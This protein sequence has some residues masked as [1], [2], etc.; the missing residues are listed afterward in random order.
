[1]G[2]F[3][4]ITKGIGGIFGGESQQTGTQ[5][6][7]NSID[8]MLKPYV[9]FGLDETKRLY[10]NPTPYAPFNTVVSPSSQTLSALSGIENRAMAGSPLMSSAQAQSQ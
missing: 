3:S 8:P 2:L 1:M 4:G 9:Q 10:Q 6:V 5:T 7:T